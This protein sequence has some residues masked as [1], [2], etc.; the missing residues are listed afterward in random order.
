MQQD[1]GARISERNNPEDTKVSEEGGG[2]RR[3]SRC[4]SK[5]SSAARGEDHG[6]A[7]CPP[8]AHGGAWWSRYPP[9]AHGGPHARSGGCLKEAVTPWGILRWSR[10]PAGPADPWREEPTLEQVCWQGLWPH[11]GPT[12]EQP[13]PEGLHP[14][15]GIYSG[16]VHG[17]LQLVGRTHTGEVHGGLSPVGGT[18]H[19]S[20]GRVWGVPLWEGRSGREN[21][22]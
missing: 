21:L 16:V 5:D 11:G 10:L 7:G 3:C 1:R 9:A 20:R 8:A 12:L 4:H 17:E 14:V 2:G 15:E 18:P 19:W 6:E 13:V 22:W